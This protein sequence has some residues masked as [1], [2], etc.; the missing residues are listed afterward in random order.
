MPLNPPSKKLRDKLL[1][2]N[3][4]AGVV[5]IE[6]HRQMV[7]G[8]LPLAGAPESVKKVVEK[9]ISGPNG[10]IPVWIYVPKKL[11][12]H[13][14]LIYFCGSGFVYGNHKQQDVISRQLA[15]T[16]G[17]KIINV[18]YRSAPENKY[19][20]GL[21]DAYAGIRWAFDHCDA[22]DIETDKIGV[23]GYSSGGNFAAVTAIKARNDGLKLACQI[24]IA[25][26]LDATRG[27]PSYQKYATGYLLDTEAVKWCFDQYLPEEMDRADP[28]V[29]PLFAPDLS[30]LAPALVIGAEYD[31]LV[32]EGRVYADR[33]KATGNEVRYSLYT[34][35]LHNF[36]F[37][38]GELEEEENAFDEMGIY[39][40]SVF[41][42]F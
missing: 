29:S 1:S 28:M 6:Q 42:E 25:P 7:D 35:Q 3:V 26:A 39:V 41:G 19:P 37:F 34:G 33:L 17:C 23:C 27:T 10:D 9:N 40:R 5:T 13:G 21:N 38:R 31:T 16:C 24:L 4:F 18:H 15:N 2:E 8:L 36:L 14:A 20:I 12:S 22:L 30:N 11:T 32:D